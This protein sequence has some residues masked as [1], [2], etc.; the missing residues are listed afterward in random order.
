MFNEEWDFFRQNRSKIPGNVFVGNNAKLIVGSFVAHSGAII[1]VNEGATLEVGYNTYTNYNT[2]IACFNH[3]K[4]GD[5]CAISEQVTIRDSN[6]H[7]MGY[8]G[9]IK[10]APVIIGNH[11]WI[12][13][14][15]TILS[16][17]TIGDGAVIGAGAVVNKDVPPHSLAVGVPAKV[18]KHDVHWY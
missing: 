1:T 9:Y 5:G 6:N 14:N 8:E 3:I 17:V 10:S 15:V 18:V 16:G 13:L 11:V 2:N 12:G 7:D 4:I